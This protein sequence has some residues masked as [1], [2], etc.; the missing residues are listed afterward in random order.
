LTVEVVVE[1]FVVVVVVVD[2]GGLVVVVV[3]G[4]G[5]VETIRLTELPGVTEAPTGGLVPM[6]M[7][8]SCVE[9]WLVGAPVVRPTWPSTFPAAI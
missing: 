2:G 7:P 5:P 6:T 9:D 1:E 3:G 8:A 4:G